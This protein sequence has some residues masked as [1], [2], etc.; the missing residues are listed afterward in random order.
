MYQS[1]YLLESNTEYMDQVSYLV[2]Y[3]KISKY[4]FLKIY[5]I[6]KIKFKNF[7]KIFLRF[8]FKLLKLI[9]SYKFL[10]IIIPY[11]IVIKTKILLSKYPK[12][13]KIIKYILLWLSIKEEKKSIN[14]SE[15]LIKIIFLPI[16][17]F[18]LK[19]NK[20]QQILF[21]EITKTKFF[22]KV[23]SGQIESKLI[24]NIENSKRNENFNQENDLSADINEVYQ[25]IKFHF[26]NYQIKN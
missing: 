2:K 6:T 13:H 14:F 15:M 7:L 25:E 3:F 21:N 20:L 16:F 22:Q 17:R 26:F 23:Y 1:S 12:F 19:N 9:F 5:I 10:K 4:Y 11:S 18:F 24:N 8:F